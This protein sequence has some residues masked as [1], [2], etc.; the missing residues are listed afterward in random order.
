MKLIARGRNFASF[1]F[2]D[3]KIVALRDGH[4]DMPVTRLRRVGGDTFDQPPAGTQMVDN[5]LR[6]SVNAFLIIDG[7]RSTLVDTGASDT[8]YSTMGE[9]VDGV[10]EAGIDRASITEVLL[11]HTHED[12]VNGLIAPD[13]SEAFP[14]ATRILVGP[15]E[16]SAFTG[17]LARLRDR[18]IP[19]T[20]NFSV[21]G[22]ITAVRATGH[23]PGH[24]AYE[25]A[26][27]VGRLLVWGDIIHVPSVQFGRPEISWEYDSNQS[28]AR[29]TRLALLER[30]AQ[31]NYFVAG[32]HLDFPGIGRVTANDDSFVFHP[33]GDE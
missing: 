8:W 12:H 11:T 23:S 13:G 15:E 25:V 16:I 1:Q 7:E 28:R 21:S 26:S 27:G 19:V 30:A 9:L 6:L 5:Q 31:P 3:L 14:Q 33:L 4:V 2:G 32:A 20:D 10:A 24:M 22:R 29:D 17:R 18:V